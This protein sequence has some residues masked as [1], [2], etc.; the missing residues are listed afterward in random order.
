MVHYKNSKNQLNMSI[1][2]LKKI[3]LFIFISNF[4][5]KFK[6]KVAVY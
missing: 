2:S 3:I 6:N 5:N 1:T 4:I